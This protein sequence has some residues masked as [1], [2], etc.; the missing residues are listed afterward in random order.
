[1]SGHYYGNEPTT[2][3]DFQ[4]AVK[5]RNLGDIASGKERI[6]ERQWRAWAVPIKADE[7]GHATVGQWLVEAP[8]AHPFWW[9]Y[10]V[11][12]VHL[13]PVEGMPPP[14][15]RFPGASH[16]IMFVALNP[17][18]PLPDLDD[19]KGMS[20]LHPIDLE[21]QFIVPDDEAA[22]ELGELAVRFMLR[23]NSPDQDFRQ[24][25]RDVINNTAEHSRLGGHPG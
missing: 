25:W 13:R 15:I 20:P 2:E 14:V 22:R 10:C 21:H 7:A 5:V 11:G 4:E 23:G 19:W 12:V 1:M 24:Y 16:E 8:G 6:E 18:K 9:W 17:E 3:P